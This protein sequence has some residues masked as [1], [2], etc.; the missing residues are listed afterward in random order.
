[1]EYQ[2]ERVQLI[3]QPAAVV[4]GRVPHDG[5]PDFL[6]GVF[7]EVMGVLGAQGVEPAGP[8]FGCYRLTS[9]GFEVEAG[10]PTSTPVEPAGRVVPSTLPGGSAI[11]VLHQGPYAGVAAAYQAG[12]AWLAEHG[13]E[14]SAPPWESYLDEPDVAEPRTLV[15][16]PCRLR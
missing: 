10:F 13:G 7:G 5:I 12:E 8:P 16:M 14:A 11:Q 2:V 1:M 6:G 4:R 3:Q 9:D 15:S